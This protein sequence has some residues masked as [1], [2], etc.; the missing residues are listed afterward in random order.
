MKNMKLKILILFTG[1]IAFTACN[2][3]DLNPLSEGSSESWYSNE[4]EIDMALN[5]IYRSVFW[6]MDAEDWTDDWTNRNSL[7]QIS[8]G[9]INGEW[10][11]AINLWKNSYKAISRANT[12]LVNLEK[13]AEGVPQATLLQFEAEAKFVRASQYSMLISHFGDVVYFTEAVDLEEA[14]TMSRTDK[15]VVLGHIYDDYDF[16]IANLPE[17]YGS[18]DLKRATK[19]TALGLKARIALYNND[20]SVARSAASACMNLDYELY[21]DFAELFLSST[22]NPNEVLFSMPRATELNVWRGAA[23]NT[24]S[25]NAGGWGNHD[26]SWDLWCAYLCTDGLPIDE[27]PLFNPQEPFDNRDPRL[28]MTIVEFQTEHLGFMYQPHPDSIEVLN[29]NTG[30]YQFNHDTRTN[31]TYASFNALLWKKGVDEDWSDDKKPQVDKFI[32]R[33]ADILL[34]Y[35]EASIELGQIDQSVLDAINMVRARAYGVDKDDIASYPAITSTNKDELRKTVRIERRMELAYEGLRY[36]DIIRWRLAEKVLNTNIYGM[37]DPAELKEKIVDKGLWFFPETPQ[38]DE[39]GVTDF[40][41]MYN[42]GLFKLLAIRSF[43]ATRQYLWPIPTKEILIN[44]NLKQN[45]NY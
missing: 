37:L 23:A 13:V 15:D 21:P 11:T 20:W 35:A 31:K 16:A 17:S 22:K 32:I 41:P 3:L 34:M 5:D 25:R 7:S 33:Y 42:Q 39:D 28:T 8:G 40:D 27:S 14:F 38:V 26:P 6:P 36:M 45:P 10:G 30:K 1:I 24:I 44:D 4:T 12:I 43:D 2:D 29:F 18:S 19:G 9:T